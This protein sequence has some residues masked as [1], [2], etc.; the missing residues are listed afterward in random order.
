MTVLCCATTND[1]HP[2]FFRA[3]LYVFSPAITFY[4][5]LLPLH[6]ASTSNHPHLLG[7]ATR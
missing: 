2:A 6:T 4:L 5:S 7:D 1:T 3:A